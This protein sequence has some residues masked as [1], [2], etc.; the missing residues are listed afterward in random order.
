MDAQGTHGGTGLRRCQLTY[1]VRHSHVCT[2]DN[3]W[4]CICTTAAVSPVLTQRTATC[5][6]LLQVGKRDKLVSVAGRC[7]CRNFLS[8]HRQVL[9]HAKF[10]LK[11]QPYP[12][13]SESL[14]KWTDV[15]QHVR[16]DDMLGTN[17]LKNSCLHLHS[18]KIIHTDPHML[19]WKCIPLVH[20]GIN[21]T[22]S[23]CL[24]V[25]SCKLL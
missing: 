19:H 7:Q 9:I 24:V 12:F 22:V 4:G 14:C 25:F 15:H 1:L 18:S 6:Q 20:K 16:N 23:M 10:P 11:W 5:L 2:C 8:K 17:L 3:C 21:F 13:S